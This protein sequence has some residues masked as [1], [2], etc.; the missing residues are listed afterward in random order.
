MSEVIRLDLGSGPRPFEGFSGVDKVEGLTDYQVDFDT[1]EPWPF[2]DDSVSEL[3]S[4]HCIEHLSQIDPLEWVIDDLHSVGSLVS[5]FAR[6][7][8][9]VTGGHVWVRTT[10]RKNTLFHF[11]DEAFRIIKPGGAFEVRWPSHQNSMSY[12]DPTH[13]RFLS[14]ALYMYLNRENRRRHGVEWYNVQC[15]WVG[16]VSETTSKGFTCQTEKERWAHMERAFTHDWN[17]AEETVMYLKAE[18]GTP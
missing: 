1:G 18:K 7:D 16:R 13:Q 3:R 10:R 17:V 12:G 5:K 11:F 14:G 6:P 15:N 8:V 9:R 2:D 4:S